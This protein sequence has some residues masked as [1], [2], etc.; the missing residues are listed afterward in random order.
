MNA[1]EYRELSGF[2]ALGCNA[3]PSGLS[4]TLSKIARISRLE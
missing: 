4:H 2:V 1:A 3:A